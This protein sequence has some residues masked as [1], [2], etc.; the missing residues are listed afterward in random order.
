MCDDKQRALRLGNGEP[1]DRVGR[2]S[3]RGT[4][5]ECSRQKSCRKSRI[6]PQHRRDSDGRSK[7]GEAHED[8]EQH[9]FQSIALHRQHELRTDRIADAEQEQQEQEGFGHAGDRHMREVADQQSGE[10]RARNRA[11][12]ECSDLEASDPV[13]RG[14]YQEQRELRIT[15][16]KLLQPRQHRRQLWLSHQHDQHHAPDREQ[17]VSDGVGDGIP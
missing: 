15:Y 9:R 3:H 11:E 14:D 6:Q 5:A 16:E 7:A 2:G 8:R 10:K 17:R 4:L 1:V 12:A 13:A